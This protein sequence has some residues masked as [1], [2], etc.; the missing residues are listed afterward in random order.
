M[1]YASDLQQAF[2]DWVKSETGYTTIWES[3]NAPR[4]QKPYCSLNISSITQFGQIYNA[5]TDIDGE[6]AIISELDLTLAVNV[7]SD[8]SSQDIDS[9]MTLQ[10]LYASLK[11]QD[12]LDYFYSNGIGFIQQLAMTNISSLLGTDFEQRAQMELDFRIGTQ[13][14]DNVG[15][16]ETVIMKGKVNDKDVDIEITS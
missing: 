13:I 12:N 2:S 7:F 11:K 9:L 5:T 1:A 14:I 4:P 3:A 10:E 15:W 16:I 6:V 8:K